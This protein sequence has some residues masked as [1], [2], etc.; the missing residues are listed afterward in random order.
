MR[1]IDT[2]VIAKPCNSASSQSCSHEFIPD[3]SVPAQE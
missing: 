3:S 1:D 2:G